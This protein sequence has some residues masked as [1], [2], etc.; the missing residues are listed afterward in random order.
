MTDKQPTQEQIREFWFKVGLRCDNVGW[1]VPINEVVAIPKYYIGGRSVPSLNFDTLFK[2][3]APKVKK[4]LK[5]E[6]YAK[7]MHNWVRDAPLNMT[8]AKSIL[9]IV[10]AHSD[11]VDSQREVNMTIKEELA[12]RLYDATFPGAD[13]NEPN[14][15]EKEP[16]YDGA[17]EMLVFLK[18]QIEQMGFARVDIEGKPEV[19]RFYDGYLACKRDI[20]ALFSEE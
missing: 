18:S 4:L 19:G 6:D 1:Y 10:E 20:L 3:A 7:L 15:Y 11:K 8:Y 2:Y 17:N 5:R 9:G 16:F 12:Q 13:W 14:E